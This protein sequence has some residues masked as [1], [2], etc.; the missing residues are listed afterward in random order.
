MKRFS[1]YKKVLFAIFVMFLS[2]FILS[3]EASWLIKN[4]VNVNEN[5]VE[6]STDG[7]H[8][9]YIK[10]V[11][12]ETT[13]EL[14]LTSTTS[15]DSD[16]NGNSGSTTYGGYS[17]ET[18]YNTALTADG[19]TEYTLKIGNSTTTTDTTTGKITT[20][21][22]TTCVVLSRKQKILGRYYLTGEIRVYTNTSIKGRNVDQNVKHEYLIKNGQKFIRPL[23]TRDGYVF[24]GYLSSS[25]DGTTPSNQ[26]FDFNKPI[27]SNT[28]IYAEWVELS[29][30]NLNTNSALTTHVNGV[31]GTSNIYPSSSATFNLS[32]DASYNSLSGYIA[33]GSS[34]LVT[35][36]KS[37][38]TINFALAT[39]ATNQEATEGAK[40]TDVTAS[41]SSSDKYI[42]VDYTNTANVANTKDYELVLQND[43]IING[44]MVIGGITGSTNANADGPQGLIMKNYV[45]LDLNGHNIIINNGGVLH[46]FGFITD[47]VGTGKITVNTGGNLKTQLVIYA[48][49]GGN[50]TLWGYSKGIAPFE[51]Y[52]LPYIDCNVELISTS[53]A[54]GSLDIFTKFNLGSLGFT[55]LYMRVFGYHTSSSPCLID[56]RAKSGLNGKVTIVPKILNKLKNENL[57]N[58]INKSLV[59]YKNKFTFTNVDSTMNALS[60]S[61]RVFIDDVPLL[62]TI[63]KDFSLDLDRV[64]FPISPSWDLSFINS[65]LNLAQCINFMPGSTLNMDKDSVLNL[66][67]YKGTGTTAAQKT[68]DSVSVASIKTL[69]GDTKYISGSIMALNEPVNNVQSLF[70]SSIYGLYASIYANYW[71]YFNSAVININGT[72]NMNT[73]NADF[74]K[75]AGNINIK[76]FSVNNG[77]ASEWNIDNLKNL[78]TSVKLQTYDIDIC[79]V[80]F[81]WFTGLSASATDETCSA[82]RYY[83]LPLISRGVA[84]V[85]DQTNKLSGSWNNDKAVFT[86]LEGQTYFLKSNNQFLIDPS[87]KSSQIDLTLVPTLCTVT[88]NNS[89][90]DSSG[91]EYVYYAG[92]MVPVTSRTDA[93]TVAVNVS[94]LS[95]KDVSKDIT[96][97]FSS[98]LYNGKT[99]NVWV[100]Q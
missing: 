17:C 11:T 39:G 83:T 51:H 94:K 41:T 30:D 12:T 55:N 10:Y 78:D 91:T 76:K 50:H 88:E 21:W 19:K 44:T 43:L 46:S 13:T 84:Y 69:P 54:S 40:I 72:L 28:N 1:K 60:P 73:G 57:N 25:S 24:M 100:K 8:N 27:T 97:K 20:K 77:T 33:L 2:F 14:T 36:I 56:I 7:Y 89:V 96:L 47:S 95:T 81:V 15:F 75:I 92:Y 32:N 93:N 58:V 49:K 26:F 48:I 99:Y 85:I 23:L 16:W 71:K 5:F 37:G 87:T 22:E 42:S 45:K 53:T 29:E 63:D 9:V 66:D 31:T 98:V 59:Y 67:Y 62:G 79:A 86:S 82:N 68:F 34:S 61:V 6:S 3:G 18:I 64:S 4:Y 52:V 35:T 90:I 70:D 74:Y 38:A 65:N 80:N